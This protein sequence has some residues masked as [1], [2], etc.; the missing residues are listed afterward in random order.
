MKLNV[1][2]KKD[3][4]FLVGSI[5]SNQ[6]HKHYAIQFSV[7]VDGTLSI[8]SNNIKTSVKSAVLIKPTI[9]HCVESTGNNLHLFFNP[10]S[11][12]G[13][14]INSMAEERTYYFD[15]SLISELQNPVRKY[16]AEEIN[17]WQLASLIEHIVKEDPRFK[18]FE[19]VIDNRILR[20]FDFLFA[21]RS[22]WVSAGECADL[23]C[24]SKSRFLHFFKEQTGSTFRRS[25]LW[26]RIMESMP[27]LELKGI[28]EAAHLYGFFDNAHYGRAFKENLGF[29]PK[30]LINSA[31]LYNSPEMHNSTFDN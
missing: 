29:S 27:T 17:I 1:Y 19:Q 23:A 15:D 3:W 12:L 16:L 10:H 24:L 22:R 25:Q 7:V 9:P 31:V 20:V 18:K 2:R 26:I 21:N 13:L 30:A 4:L 6:L 14:F 5:E 8:I 11:K 28:A